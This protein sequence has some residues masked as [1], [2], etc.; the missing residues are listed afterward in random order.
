M[1][2]AA[3]RGIPKGSAV[4]I[5]TGSPAAMVRL[6]PWYDSPDAAALRAGEARLSTAIAES[7][8]TRSGGRTVHLPGTA[9]VSQEPGESRSPADPGKPAVHGTGPQDPG[10][11]GP[12]G[13][14]ADGPR[15]AGRG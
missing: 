5:A 13:N 6:L 3:V 2:A 9:L 7:A 14:P 15:G 12:V 10:G 11:S 1:D 4:L 8:R